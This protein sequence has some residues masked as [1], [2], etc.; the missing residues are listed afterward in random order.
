MGWQRRSRGGTTLAGDE[1]FDGPA[2][3]AEAIPGAPR[4]PGNGPSTPP[5]VQP[6]SAPDPTST[7]DFRAVFD[8]SPV[9]MAVL[10]SL[11]RVVLANPALGA[12]LGR[13]AGTL[14]GTTLHDLA[15]TDDVGRFRAGLT[16]RRMRHERGH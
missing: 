9:G 12:F 13:V 2:R 6:P 7:P 1:L 14:T 11:G 4:T 3:Y 16:E 10:D 8:R 15:A 5:A